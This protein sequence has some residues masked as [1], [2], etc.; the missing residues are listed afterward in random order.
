MKS[1][2]RTEFIDQSIYRIDENTSKIIKC[3]DL[4]SEEEV[5]HK[6]NASANS[7]ANLILHLCGNIRQ[8]AVSSLNYTEDKRERELEFTTNGGLNKENLLQ[9]LNQTIE[10]AKEAIKNLPEEK[11]LKTRSVQ[12]F[13]FSAVGIIVHVTEHYSYHTGQIALITK[14]IKNQDLGFYAGIDLNTKNKTT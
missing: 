3:L 7:I 2:F 8:Y 5:W 9:E 12:G 13:N 10:D 1:I 11:L 4:L 6:P 14:L